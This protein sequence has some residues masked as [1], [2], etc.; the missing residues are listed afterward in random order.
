M[1]SVG[2]PWMWAAF[3]IFVLFMLF[4]DLFVLGGRGSHK[5]SI[6]EA[7][8]WSV[9]WLT[10]ALLFNL[11]LWWYLKRH[12]GVAVANQKCIEFLTAYVIEKSL[13]VDNI[14]VFL[15][16]F[17]TFKVDAQYQRRVLMYGVLGAIVL[18]AL[19]ILAGTWVV[20]EFNWILYF[21]GGFLLITGFRMLGDKEEDPNVENNA[22]L[23]FA[24]QH[25]RIT[26]YSQGNRFMTRQDGVF[27]F[28]PLFLVLLLIE[29]ADVVFAA[30]SIPAVFAV[31]SDPFIVFTSNI[32]AILGLRALYFLL[33][34]IV[35][36]FKFLKYGLAIVLMFIGFKML[37]AYWLH[38]PTGLSLLVIA[39]VLSASVI[40]SVVGKDKLG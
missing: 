33:L 35:D 18:R 7:A 9:A 28:T 12:L 1:V 21:F 20:Q 34:D 8:G 23:R 19:I 26:K 2:Q 40:A 17:A 31:T 39:L 22:L 30:D 27:Y 15:M 37:I 3:V 38:V 11:L 29:S 13:S 36:R 6:K 25:L 32:F 10:M 5:V 16:I 4:F 14:F 24:S